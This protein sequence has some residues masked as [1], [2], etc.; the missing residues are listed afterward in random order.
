M[1]Q[2]LQHLYNAIALW[3]QRTPSQMAECIGSAHPLR[4]GDEWL[5]KL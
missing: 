5:F 2:Q 4:N 3:R 1:L